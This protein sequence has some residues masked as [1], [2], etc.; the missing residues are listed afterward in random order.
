MSSL[1]Q[2]GGAIASQATTASQQ[3][4]VCAKA[5]LLAALRT[6]PWYIWCA[7]AA[8]TSAQ[9]GAYW[10]IS[11][12][13]SIGRDTFW[14][15]AH[16]AI[17]ACGV[18]S[19]IAYGYIILSTT[20]RRDSPLRPSSVRILG[21][22]APIGAFIASWGGVAMLTSAPFD[23]WWHDAYGLDVQIVSPPHLVLFAG[24][25][26]ILIGTSILIGGHMNRV[27]GSARTAAR[28]VYLY[29]AGILTIGIAVLLMEFTNRIRLHSALP[30]IL[31][32]AL[33]PIVMASVSRVTKFPFAATAVAAMYSL[34]VIG[35]ILVL[36][37]FAAEPK[38]GPVFQPVTH[39]IPP[40]FPILVIVP[41]VLL[42]LFWRWRGDTER[43]VW[44]TAF[45]SAC[46]F[47]LALV[48]AEWPFASFLLSPA[49]RNAFFGTG[50]LS[51]GTPPYSFLARG[52]FF[53]PDSAG[54][55]TLGLAIA[56]LLGTFT[57]RF[58]ISRGQWIAAIKR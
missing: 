48:A 18:L 13:M 21:L 56:I 9:V 4:E 47:V 23:N 16:I 7:V 25:Y 43:S 26:A 15:P 14:T 5:S 52:E 37:L 2:A 19:G 31:L 1:A 34:F 35:C 32:T 55:L 45:A 42:D 38:L 50:Y 51:Y 11:W 10:D 40:Q 53:M 36:P 29:S 39:F 12:H 22:R 24:V 54:Q 57:F 30:Y 27:T 46:I 20:F 3:S 8:V 28:W 58:G 49:S 44:A 6:V 41:A 33:M 17:Y